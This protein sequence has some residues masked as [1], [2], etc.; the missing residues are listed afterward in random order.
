VLSCVLSSSC[1]CSSKDSV[2]HLVLYETTPTKTTKTT[3]GAWVSR[4]TA[5]CTDAWHPLVYTFY[6][7]YRFIALSPILGPIITW[8]ATKIFRRNFF[9]AAPTVQ[10]VAPTLQHAAKVRNML[11]PLCNVLQ[12]YASCCKGTH[13][14][15]KVRIMLQRYASCCKGTHHAAKVRNMQQTFCSMLQQVA[16][17][18]V[19]AAEAAHLQLNF[20]T[21]CTRCC[22]AGAVAV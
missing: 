18:T 1:N 7:L 4:K 6:V 10:R 21:C 19:A 22:T 3:Q 13:H 16:T 8:W 2:H 12:R 20:A 17:A 14:A 11:Y 9:E 15:A 5:P